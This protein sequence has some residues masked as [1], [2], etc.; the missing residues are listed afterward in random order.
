MNW[1]GK[2]YDQTCQAIVILI[3]PSRVF[4]HA[5]TPHPTERIINAK[6]LPLLKDAV[7]DFAKGLA[8]SVDTIDAAEVQRMLDYFKLTPELLIKNFTEEPRS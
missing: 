2:R 8:A 1:F 6:T 5:A 4:E 7:A 3:H